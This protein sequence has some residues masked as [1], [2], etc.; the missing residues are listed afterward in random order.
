MIYILRFLPIYKEGSQYT[1]ETEIKE[2]GAILPSIHTDLHLLARLGADQEPFQVL[3]VVGT[4]VQLLW[5]CGASVESLVGGSLGCHRG[6]RVWASGGPL[7]FQVE[8]TCSTWPDGLT[9]TAAR[10]RPTVAVALLLNQ[11]LELGQVDV[12]GAGDLHLLLPLQWLI[13]L[14]LGCRSRAQCDVC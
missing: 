10:C 4:T 7:S 13:L 6:F 11:P 8:P 2:K 12:E 3:L 9:A 14:H 1:L 5:N